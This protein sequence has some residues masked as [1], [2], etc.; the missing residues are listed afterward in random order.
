MCGN[1]PTPAGGV[2]EIPKGCF[3]PQLRKLLRAPTHARV[4]ARPPPTPPHAH[5]PPPPSPLPPLSP[6][7]ARVLTST[8]NGPPLRLPTAPFCPPQPPHPLRLPCALKAVSHPPHPSPHPSHP[9][10]STSRA[11]TPILHV[12]FSAQLPPHRPTPAAPA[13]TAPDTPPP[14]LDCLRA[15][16]RAHARGSAALAAAIKATPYVAAAGHSPSSAMG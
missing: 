7:L 1:P 9:Q 3:K 14:P 2:S 8:H 13:H 6:P 5:R 15:C 10:S 11:H 12:T 4:H 16:C